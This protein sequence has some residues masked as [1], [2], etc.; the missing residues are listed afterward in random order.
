MHFSL[1]SLAALVASLPLIAPS[2]GAQ[3]LH[4]TS[5]VDI[6]K[7][8]G[9]GIFTQANIL[10]G[11]QG[12]GFDAGS[13]EVLS[14]GEAGDVTLGFDVVITDGPGADFTVFEN[15]FAVGSS[16]VFAEIVYVEVSTD[17]LNFA[18]FAPS[19]VG[20][21]SAMGSFAGLAGGLPVLANV[22][23]NS[24]S[25]FDPVV[26]GGE[27]F[28][29]ADLVTVPEVTLGLVDLAAIHFVR[30]VDVGAADVDANGMLLGGNG[31][32][33]ID[34]VTVLNSNLDDLTT[35][36]RCDL[37]FDSSGRVRLTLGDPQG[38]ADLNLATLHASLNLF[39][40][41]LTNIL[42]LF[43]IASVTPT[44]IVLVTPPVPGSGLIS[45]FGVSVEDWAGTR[46]GDQLMIQG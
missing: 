38:L 18:R 14:L 39:E 37:A 15:G 10:G 30:L 4:A 46:S 22:V 13:L 24:I 12:A 23:T 20:S 1:R 11:P 41:P 21:G 9:G 7:G 34:A 36:P 25:P 27:A 26:S 3:S 44:E 31:G 45:A 40:V 29:L 6:N 17:G 33:D 8:S 32:A 2:A 28:D 5:I 42:H 19:Y 43:T 35:K 16:A